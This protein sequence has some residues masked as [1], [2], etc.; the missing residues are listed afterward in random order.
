MK[1]SILLSI[2]FLFPG[3]LI[4]AQWIRTNGP[5]DGRINA[6]AA[7]GS[8]ILAGT[9]ANGIFRSIDKGDTWTS[10]NDGLTNI[11]ILALVVKGANYFAASNGGGIFLSTDNGTS[12]NAVNNGLTDLYPDV[13]TVLGNTVFAGSIFSVYRSSNNGSDWICM[14]SPLP[15]DIILA[16]AAC[17]SN[18]YATMQQD[19]V[20][21]SHDKGE[22]WS[23][24]YI[25][26]Y[27][28]FGSFV[29]CFAVNGSDIYAGKTD[30]TIYK[31]S[32]DGANWNIIK[33]G[34]CAA[35]NNI[36][37]MISERLIP[38]GL[39][40][41]RLLRMEGSM[42]LGSIPVMLRRVQICLHF[43]IPI[44]TARGIPGQSMNSYPTLLICT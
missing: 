25:G 36:F 33:D 34:S 14:D 10:V 9:R 13:L 22:T 28:G 15:S 37:S 41:C 40:P 21:I 43:I 26:A 30:G 38:S 17:D 20:F 24:A 44:P 4:H 8:T 7:N 31:S 23:P 32:D 27:F 18:I 3:S 11:D 12:W 19:D 42:L 2:F 35:G 29:T 39:A 5:E 16:L 6:L 1:R